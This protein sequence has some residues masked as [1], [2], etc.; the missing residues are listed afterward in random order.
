MNVKKEWTE[1]V[2]KNTDAD[3]LF[4][5]LAYPEYDFED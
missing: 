5:L 2:D 3:E 1:A 4:W